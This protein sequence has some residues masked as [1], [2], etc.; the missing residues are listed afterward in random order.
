MGQRHRQ[1]QE[2][3]VVRI[4]QSTADAEPTFLLNGQS[5]ADAKEVA[6]R[7]SAIVKVRADQPIIIDPDDPVK[8]D[9]AMNIYDLAK[10]AGAIKVFFATRPESATN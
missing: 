3:I 8:M 2:D 7:L 5:I 1:S 9:V 4:G 10:G 6:I